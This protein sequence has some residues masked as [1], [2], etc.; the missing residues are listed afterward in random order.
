MNGRAIFRSLS[1]KLCASFLFV[2]CLVSV[3]RSLTA[4]FDEKIMERNAKKGGG[5]LCRRKR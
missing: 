3:L 2:T 4:T 5:C 1:I